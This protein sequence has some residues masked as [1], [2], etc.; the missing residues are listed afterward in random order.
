MTGSHSKPG[1]GHRVTPGLRRFG[2]LAFLFMLLLGSEV[3]L[4]F[5][6]S[7]TAHVF[8]TS[9]INDSRAQATPTPTQATQV[10]V[11]SVANTSQTAAQNAD[12]QAVTSDVA[13][14][15]T[16]TPTATPAQTPSSIAT[17]TSSSNTNHNNTTA[18]NTFDKT[19]LSDTAADT[20]V[21]LCAVG[22][23]MVHASQLAAQA[24]ESG[25]SFDNNFSAIKPYVSGATVAAC[26]LE[27]TFAGD[28]GEYRTYPTFSSP[29]EL[30]TGLK[31]AGF[32][33]LSTVNNH[34]FD[35]GSSGVDHTLEVV[36]GDG[37][38]A[39]GTRASES[40]KT[41]TIVDADGVKLG[42]T[43]WSYGEFDE[44][45]NALLNGNSATD[46]AAKVNVFDP[47]DTEGSC[48]RIMAS[49]DQMKGSDLQVVII[50]WGTEY[51]LSPNEAQTALAQAL[52]DA[53]VDIII[54]SHP[55]VVQPVEELTSCDGS[56]TCFVAYSL[57]NAI[58]DQ[59]REYADT[60]AYSEDGL[61]V[62]FDITRKAS[63]VASVKG[64]T[65]TPTWVSKY[66]TSGGTE[67]TIVPLDS[68]SGYDYASNPGDY[69]ESYNRTASRITQTD[70]IKC[71]TF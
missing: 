15:P 48:A 59:R 21:S 68:A 3:G 30:A 27:T 16:P 40:D 63:G 69:I 5:A 24:R 8:S 49:V 66:D 55:H 4:S 23:M 58:A 41:Y 46:A 60:T 64:V 29:E 56:N 71:S 47:A 70:T 34:A 31:K 11:Q 28:G 36:E 1:D 12:T 7:G 65:C 33:V 13:Q 38:A 43:A 35:S 9:N 57:G 17:A 37:M 45:G 52:C 19:K 22:D 2:G 67:F 14:K 20:S 25:Y 62:D 26:N 54:G 53:G 42:V 44:G 39:V 50:H 18:A 61:M 51:E 10:V 32:D 6:A